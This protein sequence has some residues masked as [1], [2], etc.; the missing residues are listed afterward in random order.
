ML[1]LKLICLDYSN[2]YW[3]YITEK[4]KCDPVWIRTKD[5]LLRRQL[6][7]PTELRDLILKKKSIYLNVRTLL[8]KL[9]A[10]GWQDSNLRPL[11]PKASAI[12]GYAT[13][14]KLTA[15]R[16]G[17]EPSVPLPVRMFSK[18]VLSAS[19]ASLLAYKRV[20]K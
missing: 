2:N 19:Q 15:E 11:A 4:N 12:P 10:S 13:P 18:H 3:K 16:E 20:Q 5:L 7:Y 1:A 8:N 17:F 6:L 9:T 14:R